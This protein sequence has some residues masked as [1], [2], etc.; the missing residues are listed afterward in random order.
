ML[1]YFHGANL[2]LEN[3]WDYK[4]KDINTIVYFK[5]DSYVVLMR[6]IESRM[7]NLAIVNRNLP[8]FDTTVS[9]KATNKTIVFVTL[10]SGFHKPIFFSINKTKKCLPARTNKLNTNVFW[11]YT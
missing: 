11:Y 3:K 5:I 10:L 8:R 9:I 7:R 4:I 1:F 6:F 2:A